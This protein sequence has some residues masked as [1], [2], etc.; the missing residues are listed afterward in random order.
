MSRSPQTVIAVSNDALRPELLDMLLFDDTSYAVIVV[1]SIARA[2]SRISQL[3]ACLV[4][5]LMEVDDEHACLL[6]SMLQNDRAL[7]GVKVSV[8][9][10]EPGRAAAV[11]LRASDNCSALV[12]L[13]PS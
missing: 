11:S 5:L 8:C 12:A 7:R 3:Q 9:S 10:R 13:A 4:V 2:Y 1:E 6:L